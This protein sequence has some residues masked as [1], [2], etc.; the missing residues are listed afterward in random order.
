MGLGLGEGVR[1]MER[2]VKKCP[3]CYGTKLEKIPGMFVPCYAIHATDEEDEF[4]L[5]KRFVIRVGNYTVIF[6]S[7]LLLRWKIIANFSISDDFRR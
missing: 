2:V 7:Y 4:V 6:N 1:G 5:I 3:R